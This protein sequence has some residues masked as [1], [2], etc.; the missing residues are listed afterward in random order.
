MATKKKRGEKLPVW[1]VPEA[2][3]EEP[4]KKKPRKDLILP[5]VRVTAAQHARIYEIAEE[6]G[7][8]VSELIRRRTLAE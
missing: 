8:G 6:S 5:A 2:P 7:I 4:K 3:D 1:A